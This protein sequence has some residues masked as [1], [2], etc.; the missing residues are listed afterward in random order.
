M[1]IKEHILNIIHY[2]KPWVYVGVGSKKLES[3]FENHHNYID[4]M[5]YEKKISESKSLIK[6][7]KL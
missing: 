5:V 3:T 2:D 1:T 7:Y 4:V 6:Y